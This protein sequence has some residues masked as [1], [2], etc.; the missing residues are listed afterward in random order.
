M[1]E[2]REVATVSAPN[3]VAKERDNIVATNM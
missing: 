3:L 1:G 2:G